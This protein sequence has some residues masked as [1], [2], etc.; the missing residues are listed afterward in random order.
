MVRRSQRQVRFT[1]LRKPLAQAVAYALIAGAAHGQTLPHGALPAGGQVVAGQATIGAP[2]GNRLDIRQQSQNAVIDWRSFNIGAGARVDFS[3]PSH[4]SI[5]L[6]RVLGQDPSTI[7]GALNANG[8]IFILNPNGVLF[9]RGAQVNVGGLAAST[10]NLSNADFM[11]GR[12]NFVRDGAAGSVI[13]AGDIVANGGMVA[14]IGPHVSNQ[15]NITANG[16]SVALAAGERVTLHMN[17]KRLIGLAVD[18]GALNAAADNSGLINA[19]GGQVL[20]TDK[21]ADALIQS[22]VNNTGVV[23]AN[24]ISN[25]NGVIRLEGGVINNDGVLR[26]VGAA[27]GGSIALAGAGDVTL[28]ANS[29]IAAGG[30]NGGAVSV[31]ARNG[32]LLADGRIDVTGADGKG[33]SVKLLGERVGLIAHAWVDAS[34]ASGGGTVLVGGDYQGKNAAV[35]NAQLTYVGADARINADARALGAGGF[36]R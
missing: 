35:Q 36:A 6:N 16:G 31:Q 25:V 29:V 3:Q 30:A 23:E 15:G 22:V 7:L 4:S 14:L 32:T 12:F 24:A 28:G 11:A 1:A 20:L 21:A 8:Q 2:L 9:G 17:G 10:L 33:G 26:S 34:G 13:N 18:Q 5:A 27:R 19:G